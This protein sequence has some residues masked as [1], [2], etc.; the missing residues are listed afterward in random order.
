DHPLAWFN[1]GVLLQH[2]YRDE[3][4]L[5]AYREALRFKPDL[6]E[7]HANIG[8]TLDRFGRMEDAVAALQ[9]AAR[10]K[11]D[12]A[13]THISLRSALRDTGRLADALAAFRRG[14][15]LGQRLPSWTVPGEGLIKEC[16]RQVVLD[17]QFAAI[18]DGA[19]GPTDAADGLVL[20]RLCAARR[21]YGL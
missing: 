18:V 1:L 11:P 15:E 2:H 13:I 14:H 21:Y 9:T 6:A 17:E 12:S 19:V 10:L 8:T 3:E 4:A 16:E 20:A 7:A 5:A